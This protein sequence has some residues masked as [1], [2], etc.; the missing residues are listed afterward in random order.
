MKCGVRRRGFSLLEIIAAMLIM[1]ILASVG[2]NFAQ[3]QVSNAKLTAVSNQLKV[4]SS[5]VE[6]AVNNMGFLTQAEVADSAKMEQ[7]IKTWSKK[8]TTALLDY[9][10]IVNVDSTD[11]TPYDFQGEHIGAVVETINKEDS[12][13]NEYRFYYMASTVTEDYLVVI[14]SAG[15]DGTWSDDAGNGY[16]TRDDS[17]DDLIIMMRPR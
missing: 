2:I 11:T 10:N 7:Y 5:D 12:W 13:G 3:K 14:A 9:D 15:P 6:S 4:F 8:Y 16:L 17:G 1:T